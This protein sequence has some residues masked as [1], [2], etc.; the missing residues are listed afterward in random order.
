[1]PMKWKFTWSLL[2]AFAVALGGSFAQNVGDYQTAQSGPWNQ[3]STWQIWNGSAWVTPAS[4]PSGSSSAVV[5]ILAT[6]A[7]HTVTVSSGTVNIDNLTVNGILTVNSGTTLNLNLTNP[8]VINGVLNN[9][10]T[11][12]GQTSLVTINGSYN[13]TRNGGSIPSATWV[14]GSF[15]N[16]TGVT[17][18]VP[19]GLGQSF[20]SFIWNCTQ[21]GTINF[22]GN[23]T[24]V[25][26]NLT[27][28]STNGQQLQLATSQAPV[29][30]IGGNLTVSGNSRLSF[31]TTGSGATINVGGNF[32]YQSTNTTGSTLKSSGTYTLNLTGDFNMNAGTSSAQGRLL[33]SSGAG[34]ATWNLNQGNFLL[35][36]GTLTRSG[37]A[38]VVNFNFAGLQTFSNDSIG[39]ISSVVNFLVSSGTTLDMPVNVWDNTTDSRIQGTGTF[40]LN[41]TLRVGSVNS[42]G[43]IVTGNTLGNIRNS[44]VRTYNS[45]ARI[46]YAG[47]NAQFIGNGHPTTAGV[48]TEIDN[49]SDVTFNTTTSGN[50]GSAVLTIPNNLILTNGNFN[51][52]ST[53]TARTLTLDGNVTANSNNIT[54]AG[55]NSSLVINGTGS[56]GTFPFPTGS[57]TLRNFTLN[58]TSSGSVS[59]SNSTLTISGTTTL[60]NGTV[61]FGGT[62]V[63]TG[64]VS[65]ATGTV[66]AFDNQ[67]LT[68]GADITYAGTGA[69]SASGTSTLTM[70]SGAAI[71]SDLVFLGTNNTLQSLTISYTNSSGTVSIGSSGVNVTNSLTL[72]DGIL[73][74]PTAGLLTMGNNSLVTRNVTG[75]SPS[76][77]TGNSPSGGPW[78]LKY[79]G[80][81]SVTTGLEI[82]S[83]GSPQI[84]GLLITTTAG[85]VTLGQALTIG[86][87]GITQSGSS[88]IFTCGANAV[89]TSSFNQTAGTFTA[90][91]STLTLTGNLTTSGSAFNNNSGTI[92]FNGTS[93]VSGTL[94]PNYYAVTIN[95]GASVTAPATWNIQSNFSNSGTFN[96]GTGTVNFSGA[97]VQTISGS[98]NTTFYNLTVNKSGGSLTVSSAET[99]SNNFTLTAGTCNISSPVSMTNTTGLLTL[100]AGTMAITSNNLSLANGATISRA[101]GSI[102]ASSPGGGP[103]NLVYTGGSKTTG[104]EIPSSGSVLTV[105]LNTNNASTVILQ[106]GQALSVTNAFTISNSGR[107]FNSG[108]NNVTVGSLSNNGTFTAPSATATTGLTLNGDFT[109][110]GTYN[111]NGGTVHI[112]AAVTV[113]GTAPTFNNFV[114]DAAGSFTAPSSFPLTGSL[115]NNGSFTTSGTVSFSGNTAKQI[116]GTN[117]ITFNNLTLTGGTNVNDL[118]LATTAGADVTGIV[119][120]LAPAN[121][122]VLT[123]NASCPFTLLSTA[124]RP[125]VD[126]SVAAIP[127][128]SSI[129]GN[130]TVQRYM[131]KIGV[132][133]YNYQVYHDI[134]SPV[135]TNVADLQNSLPITG[136]FTGASIVSGVT[137]SNPGSAAMAW[138]DETQTG[139][140]NTGWTDFPADGTDNTASFVKGRGYSLFVFGSDPPVT[141]NGM[142]KW[143]L[144]GPIWSGTFNLPVTYTNTGSPSDDGWNLVGNPYPSAIDWK[145]ASGWTK[146]NVDDAIYVDDYNTAN[147]VF[148]SYVNGVGTNGGTQYIA[149]GQ[150]FWV[151]ANAA[152]PVVG[153]SESIKVPG[154][155]TTFFRQAEPPNLI[156]IALIDANSL[157][158]ESV[159]YFSDSATVGFD[160]RYDARKLNNQYGY[161]NLSSLSPVNEPFAIHA[162]PFDNTACATTVP[163]KVTNVATGNYSLSFSEFQSMPSSLSIKLKDKYLGSNTDVR[164]NP[165]YVFSVDKN[166][167]GSIDSTRFSMI[168]TYSAVPA[169]IMASGVSVCDTTM[170]KVTINNTSPEFVYTLSTSQGSVVIPAIQGSGS[171]LILPVSAKNLAIGKNTF[172]IKAANSFC[173]TLSLSDTVSIRLVAPPSAPTAISSSSCGSGLITLTASGATG[174]GYYNWY[175][176]LNASYPYPVQTA[177]FVTDSLSKPKTFYVSITSSLGCE[178][179]K[180][181]VTANVVNLNPATITVTGLTTLQSNYSSGNQWYLNGSAISG[182]TGQTLTVNQSGTYGLT[183]NSQGCSV[184]SPTKDMVVTSVEEVSNSIKAYPIPVKGTLYMEVPD[185]GPTSGELYNA[186]GMKITSLGF[187]GDGLK[188]ISS[189][190]FARESAGVYFVRISQGNAITVVRIIKD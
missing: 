24:S 105:T 86:S 3:T 38:G 188:Q 64:N 149:T 139:G 19:G 148:A 22:A 137:N 162:L 93:I 97:N 150:G 177:A 176:S 42:T 178:G 54:V 158:D 108:A 44:G 55:A 167:A 127:T 120:L 61:T 151:H 1:M 6:P 2:C 169:S 187:T 116:L 172:T 37:G 26:A 181:A 72:T 186:M 138:Y 77:I 143:S 68:T 101:A 185:Q 52:V 160:K 84:A 153:V 119:T 57:Q 20:D 107:T 90:P 114:V 66:L 171:N 73:N 50:S 180:A 67:S 157:R 111:A 179:A 91:S 94:N 131:S 30:S 79:S 132:A 155:S 140:I 173:Q 121:A 70:N 14:A 12:T 129:S 5:T 190:N 82:P 41:G 43:A 53:G 23:L 124:D 112:G 104:L 144:T 117:K 128:G 69:L 33:F 59:F 165:I 92:I 65:L 27:I 100:T 32:Y 147:P 113:S 80:T 56:F 45:G 7:V 134:S 74:I 28:S 154:Q 118:T 17:N 115:T 164:Q 109:N 10:G 183:V 18:T 35:K 40:T 170:A 81:A 152:A 51:L 96:G 106:A 182:A 145:A 184:S 16:V 163:L 21:T 60:T 123:I 141:T 102:T 36:C 76:S 46:V 103:W 34:N 49:V 126:A 62:T 11:I 125:T 99:V 156:R 87:G 9:S 95:G 130:V 29:V 63:L 83:A 15:C 75:A 25:G 48:D 136:N 78:T 159:I 122:A 175:D 135:N 166:V 110:S 98:S 39:T 58:R 4:V 88:G 189:Y 174:T 133:A 89:S 8:T 85:T 13:H 146:T 31:I 47:L 142:A 168:F 71:T 161:L